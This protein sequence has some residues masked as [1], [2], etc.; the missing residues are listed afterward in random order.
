[1]LS[2]FYT[3]QML[4]L[5][6]QIKQFCQGNLYAIVLYKKNTM[7]NDLVHSIIS[8]YPKWAHLFCQIQTHSCN[9]SYP[10]SWRGVL[11]WSWNQPQIWP[12]SEETRKKYQTSPSLFCAL[13]GVFVLFPFSGLSSLMILH[14]WDE[15]ERSGVQQLAINN[16]CFSS[17]PTMWL[18]LEITA[19]LCL[20]EIGQ[21]AVL[22]LL[23]TLEAVCCLL[24]VASILNRSLQHF[25]HSTVFKCL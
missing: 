18:Q 1:M 4:H 16:S 7:P 8:Q 6:I 11:P 2:F 10:R 23:R 15:S 25:A 20:E 12:V 22:W 9:S 5:Q 19:T 21:N 3:V 14:S 17:L 24:Y 13:F